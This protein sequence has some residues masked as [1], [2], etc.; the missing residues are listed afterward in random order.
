MKAEIIERRD[1]IN[2]IQ[3]YYKK[4][5]QKLDEVIEMCQKYLKK[6]PEGTLRIAHNN[7]SVQYYWRNSNT[8]SYGKYIKCSE[9]D[10]AYQLAQKD[11]AKKLIKLAIQKKKNLQ[12]CYEKHQRKDIEDFH[13]RLSKD[14]QALIVPFV[15]SDEEYAIIWEEQ[16]HSQRY[17][18]KSYP[19][20]EE[21]GL[22]T[23]KGDLVRS[24][25]EKIIADKL[26]AMKIPYIYEKPLTLSGNIR[27]VPDFTVLNKYTRE[28]M[29]WEH[30]GMMDNVDY[31]EKAIHKLRNYQKNKI[32]QGQKLLVTYETSSQF[33]NVK[34]L[35]DIIEE[36]LMSE[37]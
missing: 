26:Y 34:E 35:E 22:K 11:Y 17:E 18:M 7:S 8:E 21:T 20:N 5:I 2:K 4:E 13:E 9:V 27:V 33:I 24:K 25:S 37:L 23:E 6:S 30:F 12:N 15:L 36:F 19:L 28:E 1:I 32:Y 16:A 3:S 31:C 14:R 10:L 29:Y